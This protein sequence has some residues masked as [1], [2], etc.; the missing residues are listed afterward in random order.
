MICIVD[1]AWLGNIIRHIFTTLLT[2]LS[3]KSIFCSNAISCHKKTQKLGTSSNPRETIANHEIVD[4]LRAMAISYIEDVTRTICNMGQSIWA[5]WAIVNFF[6]Q[7]RKP[8]FAYVNNDCCRNDCVLRS[9][10]RYFVHSCNTDQRAVN[11][12]D[13]FHMHR[14]FSGLYMHVAYLRTRTYNFISVR[15]RYLMKRRKLCIA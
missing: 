6:H 10:T 2:S 7:G 15:H 4:C 12:F 9:V 3:S 1:A 8:L 5:K 11:T 14:T 13:T